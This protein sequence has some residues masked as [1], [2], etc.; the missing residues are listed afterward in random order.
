MAFLIW[1]ST[2]TWQGLVDCHLTEKPFAR[3]GLLSTSTTKAATR[4]GGMKGANEQPLVSPPPVVAGT[5]L[6]HIVPACSPS[7]STSL[8]CAH[9]THHVQQIPLHGLG[10]LSMILLPIPP[11]CIAR[12]WQEATSGHEALHHCNVTC[13]AMAAG[14]IDSNKSNKATTPLWY[15]LLKASRTCSL[16]SGSMSPAVASFTYFWTTLPP[17]A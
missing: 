6:C 12:S 7:Y 15:S 11:C 10:P 9:P 1:S 14:G 17:R 8:T 4:V 3:C 13:G 5:F 16:Q 2:N